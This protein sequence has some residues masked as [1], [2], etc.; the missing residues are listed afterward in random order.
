M[1]HFALQITTISVNNNETKEQLW[2][3]EYY[4]NFEKVI[5]GQYQ[6]EE[7]A[8]RAYDI[9]IHK[10]WDIDRRV[11]NYESINSS[12]LTTPAIVLGHIVEQERKITM[13]RISQINRRLNKANAAMKRIMPSTPSKTNT[14]TAAEEMKTTDNDIDIAV[15]MVVEVS[16]EDFHSYDSRDSV[17]DAGALSSP[18]M[19]EDEGDLQDKKD[20]REYA[21]G[22]EDD[23]DEEEGSDDDEDEG[24]EEEGSEE[25]GSADEDWIPTSM[26]ETVYE[27][28]GPMGR[29]LRAVNQTDFP[30]IR[31][32]W[33]KYVLEWATGKGVIIPARTGPGNLSKMRQ[34]SYTEYILSLIHI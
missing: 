23:H 11:C 22:L 6:T 1:S 5:V 19:S 24:S 33:A 17:T 34:V 2:I 7:E 3:V 27:P 12:I 4:R 10:E 18:E 26:K 30:P 32:D 15:D 9:A 25:E 14:N 28:D 16:G 31:S 8:A 29:L 13:E 20:E 21:K